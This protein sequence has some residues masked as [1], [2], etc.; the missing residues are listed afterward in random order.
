MPNWGRLYSALSAS[1]SPDVAWSLA[2][3]SL[4]PLP[5][6]VARVA[7]VKSYDG[8][9]AVV[10]HDGSCL[11]VL[12][13]TYYPGWRYQVDRGPLRPV[14]KINGGLQGVPL[15]GSGTSRVLVNYQPPGFNRA[16]TITMI[17][18]STAICVL[19]LAGL[20]AITSSGRPG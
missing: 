20:R 16:A 9:T 5:E 4:P 8:Q 10:E 6:P 12:R 1:D 17:S 19:T 7:R 14:V 11:L 13:R 2:E 3:D 15:I 18:L